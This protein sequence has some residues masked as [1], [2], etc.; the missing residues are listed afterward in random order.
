MLKHAKKGDFIKSKLGPFY[1][2]HTEK[3]E[4][5]GKASFKKKKS[6][7]V[8]DFDLGEDEEDDDMSKDGF[9]YQ[10]SD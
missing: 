8:W 4:D 7:I 3:N 5:G 10:S 9:S 2:I 1:I 6:N